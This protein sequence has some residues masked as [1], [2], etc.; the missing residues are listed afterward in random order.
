MTLQTITLD[1]CG[2][3]RIF[4]HCAARRAK[5]PQYVNVDD[6]AV[7]ESYKRARAHNLR[8]N[9]KT[10]ILRDNRLGVLARPSDPSDWPEASLEEAR[11]YLCDEI[12]CDAVRAFNVAKMS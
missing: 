1:H 2:L 12:W 8:Y 3:E 5:S 6:R 11:E 4:A 10:N 9:R 7:Y